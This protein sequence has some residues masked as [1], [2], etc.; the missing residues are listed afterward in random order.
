MTVYHDTIEV[1]SD[2]RKPMFHDVTD[3]AKAAVARSGIKAGAITVYS[4]HTTCSVIIQEE[5]HDQ[6]YDGTKFLLQD[7]LDRLETLVPTCRREGQ[8]LHPGPAHIHHA[9]DD[10]GEKAVWSLNTD[11]HIRSAFVGRSETIPIVDGRI[12]LGQFGQ[13]YFVDFDGTRDRGRTVHF[14]VIGE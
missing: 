12:E 14:Q 1:R 7:M 5:S 8:Y 4:P 2:L 6:L 9:V 3:E 10:L 13:I 11:A